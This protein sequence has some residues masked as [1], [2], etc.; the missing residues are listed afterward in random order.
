M[1]RPSIPS[2][3]R[4]REFVSR[5]PL[6]ALSR[7]SSKLNA[8]ATADI[9]TH[10]T[11]VTFISETQRVVDQVPV[12]IPR[13]LI[14]FSLLSQQQT[15]RSSSLGFPFRIPTL[16]CESRAAKTSDRTSQTRAPINLSSL[17]NAAA[18]PVGSYEAGEGIG[19]AIGGIDAGLRGVL[20]S[21][22][23]IVIPSRLRTGGA[24]GRF[25]LAGWSIRSYKDNDPV[26]LSTNKLT[27]PITQLPYAY[28]ELP[29]VCPPSKDGFGRKFGS[30][31]V[32]LNL[33]EVLRGDR[34]SISDYELLMGQD[35]ECKHLCDRVVDRAAAERAKQLVRGGYVVEWLVMLVRR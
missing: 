14:S 24:D 3:F 34:I 31:N 21:R 20:H 23:A 15:F 17:T 33:G 30:R 26:P 10:L 12:S 22:F 2:N 7:H 28:H 27:S 29:F 18:H 35:T 11:T 6:S 19:A 13:S 9:T 5:C 25:R 16:V 32:G 8:D 1:I 4:N